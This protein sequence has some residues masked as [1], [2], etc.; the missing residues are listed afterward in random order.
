MLSVILQLSAV[1]NLFIGTEIAKAKTDDPSD[2]K[3]MFDFWY[4]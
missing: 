1:V 2:D 3:G 4:Q